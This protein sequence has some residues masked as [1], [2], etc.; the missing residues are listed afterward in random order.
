MVKAKRSEKAKTPVTQVSDARVRKD[1]IKPSDLKD[2]KKLGHI[3][4]LLDVVRKRLGVG[5][6]SLGSLSESV[7]VFDPEPL[8]AIAAELGDKLPN[9]TP[10]KFKNP[11]DRL[12]APFA[13]ILAPAH[14]PHTRFIGQN[15]TK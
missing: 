1:K 7:T 14:R 6:A 5:R 4:S 9:R 13:R 8:A 15:L 12:A 10:E 3:A 2:L 11:L